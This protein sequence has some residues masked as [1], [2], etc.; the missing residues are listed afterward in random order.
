MLIDFVIDPEDEE[1]EST[2]L[3]DFHKKVYESEENV[4]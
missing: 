3:V 2:F 1:G 4:S